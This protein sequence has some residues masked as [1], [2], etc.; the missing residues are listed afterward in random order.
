MI[1]F[2][3]LSCVSRALMRKE[4]K[5][6][7]RSHPLG[8]IRALNRMCLLISILLVYS[9]C[10]KGTGRL[11]DAVPAGVIEAQASFQGLNGNSVS[12]TALIYNTTPDGLRVLR[13][14]DLNSPGELRTEVFLVADGVTVFR[15]TL[16][17]PRGNQNYPTGI[18]GP[19]DWD[20]ITLRLGASLNDPASGQ[21]I[22]IK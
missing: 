6:F 12:G 10:G 5:M 16:R 3:Y 2:G 17:A 9:S 13:L 4:L 11:N 7:I 20:S 22:F 19:R 1:L 21:A 8:R 18:R 15:S 14:Q